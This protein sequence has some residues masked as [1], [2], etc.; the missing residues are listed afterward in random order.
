MLSRLGAGKSPTFATSTT[1]KMKAFALPLDLGHGKDAKQGAPPPLKGDFVPVYVALG[2]IGLSATLGMYTAMHQLS[3]APNVRVRKSLRETI[4]EVVVPEL[5]VEEG[6]KFIK[7][8][9]FRKL[10]HI[11]EKDD[12]IVPTHVNC[13]I[14]VKPPKAETLKDVGVDP[15]TQ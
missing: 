10:A 2:L 3:R 6:D 9:W 11:Q 1:P 4:P 15:K 13:E 7:K 14:L 5:T 12:P 8:S